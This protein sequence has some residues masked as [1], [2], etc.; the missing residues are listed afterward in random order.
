MNYKLSIV[1]SSIL[2]VSI[3]LF[4]SIAKDYTAHV[5]LSEYEQNL[6]KKKVDL[7]HQGNLLRRSLEL[8][9]SNAK[10]HFELGK[11]YI[12]EDPIG[13]DSEAGFMSYARSKEIFQEALMLKPTDGRNRAEYAWYLGSNGDTNEAIEHCNIAINSN[14]TDAYLHMLFAMLCMNLIHDEIDI[15][16]T[17]QFIENYRNETKKEVTLKSYDNCYINGVSIAELLRRSQI[18]WDKALS[19]GARRY[20]YE[21]E[22]LADLNFLKFELDKAIRN[23]TRAENK[24]MLA[25]CYIIKE[26]YKR[27]IN[28]LAGILKGDGKLSRL[29]LSKT[30]KLLMDIINN[31]PKDH[32]PFYWLGKLY[33]HLG[34]A[35][36]AISNY[37]LSIHIN[38]GHIDSHLDIAGLYNQTGKIDQAIKEYQ[39]I[40]E[41]APNHKKATDLLGET[42]MFQYKDAGFLK[43]PDTDFTN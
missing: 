35:E 33:T 14:T 19:L 32:Q 29:S 26:E 5:Y 18:E 17:V 8:C 30:K 3:Y 9:P 10:T 7:E 21:Y 6:K 24:Y 27:A 42:V 38:P 34:E 36:R 22:S 4:I 43:K 1:Y 39:I 23:Y 20:Q 28:I 41:K 15:T 31:G 12:D 16:N 13:K 2:I 11:L 40:L 37:K 25:R